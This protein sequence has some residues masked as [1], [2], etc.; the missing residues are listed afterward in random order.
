MSEPTIED[1][2]EEFEPLKFEDGHEEDTDD[3]A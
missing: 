2:E 3:E 1:F